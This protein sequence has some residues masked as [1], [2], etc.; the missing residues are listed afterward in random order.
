MAQPRL[1][2][3][4][5]AEG[6][7][8]FPVD[9]TTRP[10]CS[11]IGNHT[12]DC[13]GDLLEESHPSGPFPALRPITCTVWCEDNDGHTTATGR[14]EQICWGKSYYVELSCEE[15]EVNF[16]GE[17]QSR[18]V[19]PSFVAVAAYRGYNQLPCINMNF[20]LVG[21]GDGQVD[22]SFKMTPLEARQLAAHLVAV[23]DEIEDGA[24]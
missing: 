16:K 9:S 18:N 19:W 12:R 24:R 23:A 2:D 4:R 3:D 6:G 1:D 5:A 21:H 10:C 7:N 11:G 8:P 22:D 20:I 14:S 15:A 17:G 13:R